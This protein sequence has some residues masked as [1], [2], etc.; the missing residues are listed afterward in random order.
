MTTAADLYWRSAD[1]FTAMGSDGDAEALVA[2]VDAQWPAM[3]RRA[4]TPEDAETCR[5][6]MLAALQVP[7]LAAEAAVWRAR[8][9]SRATVVGWTECVA[10]LAMGEAFR[11]LAVA[12][13]DF[14]RGRTLDVIKPVPAAVA[15]LEELS[16]YLTA[17]DSGIRLGP[18]APTRAVV[19]RFLHEKGGF[20]RLVQGDIAGARSSYAAAAQ[21]AAGQPRGEVKVA[22]GAALVEY[23]AGAGDPEP[24]RQLL[25]SAEQWPDLATTAR[26]NV[27]VMEA[28]GDDV[29]GYE[30][31]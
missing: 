27:A 7:E 11:M 30:I 25:P 10:A 15:A 8:A 19:E 12:N 26:H 23:V 13:E 4:P 29:L 16:V 17:P 24:T 1:L 31:L 20:L 3:S 22:L 21:A 9:L 14:P 5:L 18:M 2:A 6:T 28:G